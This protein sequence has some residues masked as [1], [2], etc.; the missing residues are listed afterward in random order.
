[1]KTLIQNPNPQRLLSQT[2]TRPLTSYSHFLFAPN[3]PCKSV[4][5]VF[6]CFCILS[7]D[8]CMSNLPMTS[9]TLDVSDPTGSYADT[10]PYSIAVPWK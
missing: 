7:D 2:E 10:T 8:L 9:Q 6:G 1:M 5:W 3:I 4:D